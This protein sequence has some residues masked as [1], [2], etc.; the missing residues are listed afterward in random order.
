MAEPHAIGVA[1]GQQM[2]SSNGAAPTTMV[3]AA[4][5]NT[6]GVG[7]PMQASA[8]AGAGKV[9]PGIMNNN[10]IGSAGAGAGAGGVGGAGGSAAAGAIYS[11]GGAGAGASASAGAGAGIAGAVGGATMGGGQAMSHIFARPQ[12]PI[13]GVA[14]PAAA[15]SAWQQQQMMQQQAAAANAARYAAAAAASAGAGVAA[16]HAQRIQNSRSENRLHSVETVRASSSRSA[17]K[18]KK[19]HFTKELEKLMYGYGDAR[20][21]TIRGGFKLE[22][23]LVSLMKYP[24]KYARVKDLLQKDEEIKKA[25]QNMKEEEIG[26]KFKA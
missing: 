6:G 24:K 1:A 25:R 18:R 19:R 4:A 5:Y 12:V 22:D 20:T 7:V 3:N 9:L 2:V 13:G 16:A 26:E 17:G 8:G 14:P 23:I 21:K 15:A 11:G 10:G